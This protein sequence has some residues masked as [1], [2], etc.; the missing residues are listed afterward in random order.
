MNGDIADLQM[1]LAFQEDMLEA[2]NHRVAEQQT[3]IDH[4]KF[5]LNYL[6]QKLR[7]WSESEKAAPTFNPVDEKPPHY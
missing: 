1:R 7:E 6:N 4:L 5:Q 3:E 2:L